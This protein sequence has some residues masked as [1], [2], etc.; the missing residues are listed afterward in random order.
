LLGKKGHEKLTAK[1]WICFSTKGNAN[2]LAKIQVQARVPCSYLSWEVVTQDRE[3]GGAVKSWW[4]ASS[5]TTTLIGPPKA[6]PS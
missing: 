3:G 6:D 5:L 1:K 2:N 4:L